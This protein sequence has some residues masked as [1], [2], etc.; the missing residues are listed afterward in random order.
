VQRG[1]DEQTDLPLD[2]DERLGAGDGTRGVRGRERRR[3]RA[4]RQ[5]GADE[6]RIASRPAR[7]S[8]V[9][10]DGLDGALVTRRAARPARPGAP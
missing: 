10:G 7:G 5:G 3:E 2:R 8:G 9:C 1:L 6:R 4:E